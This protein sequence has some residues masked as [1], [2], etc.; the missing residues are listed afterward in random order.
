MLYPAGAQIMEKVEE[1]REESKDTGARSAGINR[2]PKG[3]P[4]R[5]RPSV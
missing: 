1:G 4:R 2:W 5:E 3:I